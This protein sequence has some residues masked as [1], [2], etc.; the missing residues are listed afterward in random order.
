ALSR[1]AAEPAAPPLPPLDA[2]VA[3]GTLVRER[4]GHQI[5]D[6]LVEP[7]L[8]GVYAGRSDTLSLTATMP[9]LAARLRTGGSLVEAVEAVTTP[10]PST[11]PVFVS[12]T[13]GLARLPLAL[14]ASGRFS[15]RTGVTVR[16]I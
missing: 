8:G 15:V 7:L 4:L 9:A 16:A 3:V 5:A 2:D 11:G 1:I 13:G 6:R 14:A 10:S 12:V